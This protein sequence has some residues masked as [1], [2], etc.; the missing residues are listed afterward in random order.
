MIANAIPNNSTRFTANATRNVPLL[1]K[2]HRLI[3][4]QEFNE[5]SRISLWI[6]PGA[7]NH[8]ES[9]AAR[10]RTHMQQAPPCGH[11]FGSCNQKT[12]ADH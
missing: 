4:P 11:E 7:P 9:K 1:Q 10:R 3:S 12:V 5:N 6:A 8:S 2:C